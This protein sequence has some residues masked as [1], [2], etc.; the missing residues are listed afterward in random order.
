MSVLTAPSPP[1]DRTIAYGASPDQVYDVRR[2]VGAARRA[3]VVVIHGGFWRPAYDRTHAG[4]Q[5]K[6]LATHSFHVATIEYRR[7][8][9]DWPAMAADVL[10]AISAVAADPELPDD[11]VLLGHSA[12][13]HLATWAAYQPEIAV[14]GV[15]SL[16]G[17][18]DLH[19]TRDLH[20][21]DGAADALMGSAP[22]A[23]W[24]AADPA[25]LGRPPA[26]VRLIHGAADDRVPVEV[27]ESYQAA[28]DAAIPLQVLAGCGHY[29]LIDPA[30]PQFAHTVAAVEALL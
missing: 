19:L 21:G 29:E 4:Q 25:M 11:I 30:T 14:T 24:R 15:V 1:P 16:A 7:V 17:C 26:Q 28:A 6:A 3:T 8:P 9:G 2:P 18:V 12:G 22:E 20:L 13:G 10:A 27:S 23:V 5:S